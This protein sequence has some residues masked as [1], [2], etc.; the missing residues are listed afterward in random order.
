MVLAPPFA[1]C[2]NGQTATY[3][4]KLQQSQTWL[5]L[6][7]ACC[8]QDPK[9]LWWHDG[10]LRLHWE[11]SKK[12]PTVCILGH[13]A[14]VHPINRWSQQG[15]ARE[16]TW[17]YQLHSSQWNTPSFPS[18]L[19]WNARPHE[20]PIGTVK[21]QTIGWTQA[22]LAEAL[23]LSNEPAPSLLISWQIQ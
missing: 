18:F 10:T 5:K 16:C 3:C 12:T 23:H 11:R 22:T 8:T 4:P 19:E 13:T 17:P 7:G 14:M 20:T 15:C 6:Q 9:D 1:S 21:L 2:R